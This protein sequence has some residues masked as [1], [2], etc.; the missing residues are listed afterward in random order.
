MEG[1]FFIW[2]PSTCATWLVLGHNFG[3][4]GKEVPL[5]LA[6]RIIVAEKTIHFICSLIH[7]CISSFIHSINVAGCLLCVSLPSILFRAVGR[8]GPNA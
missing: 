2:I 5:L 1:Q 3:V 7:S 8:T 4:L 6:R